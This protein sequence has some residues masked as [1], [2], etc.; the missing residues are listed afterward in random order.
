MP[1]W[2]RITTLVLLA[3]S[4]SCSALEAGELVSDF[5]DAL[6]GVRDLMDNT[7]VANSGDLQ[8]L[9]KRACPAQCTQYCCVADGTC[10]PSRAWS[11]C[12]GGVVCGPGRKCCHNGCIDQNEECC[13]TPGKHCNAGYECW[14]INGVPK[15]CPQ[16]KCGSGGGRPTPPPPPP[17]PTLLPPPPRPT[18][19]SFDYYTWTVTWTYR[20][21]FYTSVTIRTTTTT[22]TTSVI[23]F[24]ASNS[25]DASSSF[26]EYTATAT[27]DPPAGATNPPDLPGGRGGGSG[28]GGGGLGGGNLVAVPPGT[29]GAGDM[30]SWHTVL[31][32]GAA[33]I[34]GILAVY[35]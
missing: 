34:P 23:S 24:Y 22:T 28:S 35:L 30:W 15:C 4:A 9:A 27:F 10:I 32:A 29:S 31:I 3:L 8:S 25:A 1:S 18:R 2:S 12:G 11:C 21:V 17:R 14:L 16:G 6:F 20:V 5:S 26:R 7:T 13:R 19:G 33:I